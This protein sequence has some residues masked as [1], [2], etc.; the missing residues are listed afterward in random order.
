MIPQAPRTASSGSSTSPRWSKRGEVLRAHLARRERLAELRRRTR[1]GERGALRRDVV[2][3]EPAG[4]EQRERRHEPREV[5]VEPGGTGEHRLE[6]ELAG[7]VGVVA[8]EDVAEVVRD[9]RRPPPSSPGTAAASGRR[10]RRTRPTVPARTPTDRAGGRRARR[11]P[12]APAGR[13]G[14][15]RGTAASRPSLRPAGAGARHGRRAGRARRRRARRRTPPPGRPGRRRAG[16]RRG[17]ST[18]PRRPG[19]PPPGVERIGGGRHLGGR[20]GFECPGVGVHA[21]V[22]VEQALDDADLL[23][24]RARTHGGGAEQSPRD[25]QSVRH[26]RDGRWARGLTVHE[27]QWCHST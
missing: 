5:V 24:G 26:G 2:D 14:A 13:A 3:D 23:V 12:P 22:A 25:R 1:T 19:R 17:G 6:R 15:L 10:S 11:R 16:R 20:E 8:G 7:R 9:Q 4:L 27:S 18:P 21:E